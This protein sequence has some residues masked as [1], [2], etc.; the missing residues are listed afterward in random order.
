MRTSASWS[1]EDV[2][3]G[4]NGLAAAL[5]F[6]AGDATVAGAA[7]GTN[8]GDDGVS[9]VAVAA[10]AATGAGVNDGGVHTGA[11]VLNTNVLAD[12][13]SFVVDVVF[14]TTGPLEASPFGIG[15]AR[16]SS[17]ASVILH[18]A[19]QRN[20]SC[21]RAIGR[22]WKME[23]EA[24]A[25]RRRQSAEAASVREARRGGGAD[26]SKHAVAAAHERGVLMQ[27]RAG[28]DERVVTTD[29]AS[30]VRPSWWL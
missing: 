10:G 26:A 2:H 1:R 19:A 20:R 15:V 13:F 25:W 8:A 4:T 16:F 17:R 9:G 28:A 22:R 23:E 29:A 27:Q 11:A 7:A 3:D 18:S 21:W 12:G 5:S 6:G 24:E 30:D 14:A